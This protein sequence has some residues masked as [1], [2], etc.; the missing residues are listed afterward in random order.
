MRVQSAQNWLFDEAGRYDCN[1]AS[2]QH[3]RRRG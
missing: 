2:P 1:D 3:V